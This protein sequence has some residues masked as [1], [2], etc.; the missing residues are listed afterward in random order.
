[1]KSFTGM[2][3][4]ITFMKGDRKKRKKVYL[5]ES[6]LFAVL[7]TAVD[8]VLF[9][10]T[11]YFDMLHIFDNNIWNL[12]VTTFLTLLIMFIGSYILDYIL[13]ETILKIKRKKRTKRKK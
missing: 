6:L 3:L 1:M 4:P 8:F 12:I 5:Q 7:I 11:S 2:V 10:K 13:T 9:Y